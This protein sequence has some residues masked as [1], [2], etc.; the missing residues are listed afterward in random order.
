PLQAGGPTSCGHLVRRPAHKRCAR[1][2]S[3]LWVGAELQVAIPASAMLQA[4]ATTSGCHYRGPWPH[5]IAPLRVARSWPTTPTGGLVITSHPCRGL[6]HGQPHS[7]L[8]AFA[9]KTQQ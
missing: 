3:P 8:A 7:F 9:T 1:K 2:Q 5:L 4:A 6:G